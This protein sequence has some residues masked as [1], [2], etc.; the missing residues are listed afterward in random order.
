MKIVIDIGGGWPV[1]NISSEKKHAL[2]VSNE[3]RILAEMKQ[4]LMG[5]FEVS[6]AASGASA[7]AVLEMND[8][9][10]VII[11][12]PEN[13]EKAFSMYVRIFE[14]VKKKIVP[15][16]FLAEKGN[17]KDE[18]V[19]F[20][21]GAVD[22]STRR[23]GALKALISRI[24]LRISAS[25]YEKRL[26]GGEESSPPVPAAPQTILKDK[27]ILVVDD[28]ELNRYIICDMLSEIEGLILECAADGKEAVDK[29]AEEPKRYSLILMDVQMS[30]MDGL[31]ATRA[32]RALNCENARDIPI[33]AATAGVGE[34]EIEL[35]LEAGMNGYLEKPIAYDKLLAVISEHCL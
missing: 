17:D 6:I 20:M 27:A 29:F 9:A 10:A 23:P 21:M 14:F 31:D 15:I 13:R 34:D 3:P 25:E 11:Y 1:S 35:C 7:L 22:Y 28:L 19:A 12:I 32:I 30:G 4:E 24:N 26:T 18:N 8:I 16:I 2:I 33:I 5:H